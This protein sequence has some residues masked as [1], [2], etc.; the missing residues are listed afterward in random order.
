MFLSLTGVLGKLTE[1]MGRVGIWILQG[2]LGAAILDY[3]FSMA[4]FPSLTAAAYQSSLPA[5]VV[6]TFP[7]TVN[8]TVEGGASSERADMPPGFLFKVSV[9]WWGTEFL[10]TFFL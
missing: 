1:A 6:E 10:V 3:L 2:G 7:A 4:F 5:V 8:G 9:W